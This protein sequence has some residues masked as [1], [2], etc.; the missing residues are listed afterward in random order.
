MQRQIHPQKSHQPSHP[1]CPYELLCS[2]PITGLGDLKDKRIRAAGDWGQLALALGATP[3]NMSVSEVYEGLQRGVLDCTAS[4]A[5]WLSSYSL[6]DVTGHVYAISNGAA[7]D[8]PDLN[9]SVDMW[10]RLTEDQQAIV[11]EAAAASVVSGAH[12]FISEADEAMAAAR[13]AGFD[14]VEPDTETRA[15]LGE[16]TR[17]CASHRN[18]PRPRRWSLPGLRWRRRVCRPACSTW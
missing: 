14:I 7:F 2:A 10:N 15:A 13:D 4:S 5:A 3:V 16:L 6:L 12:G 11:K 17:W 9:L 8:G 18:S 1:P